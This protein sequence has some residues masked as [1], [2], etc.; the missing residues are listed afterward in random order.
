MYPVQNVNDVLVAQ[1]VTSLQ[2]GTS[3]SPDPSHK[4]RGNL[5][6]PRGLLRK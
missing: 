5:G 6:I 1:G 2:S 4:G 3:P